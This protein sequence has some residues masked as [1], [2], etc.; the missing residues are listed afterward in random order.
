M[1]TGQATNGSEPIE[2]QSDS[3]HTKNQINRAWTVSRLTET[4]EVRHHQDKDTWELLDV[5]LTSVD[6]A[7]VNFIP[8]TG[9]AMH[10]TGVNDFSGIAGPDTI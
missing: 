10:L 8:T 5:I 6:G 3:L 1:D 9:Q 2:Y 4:T 7:A